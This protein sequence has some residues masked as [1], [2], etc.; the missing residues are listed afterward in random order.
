[1]DSAFRGP[2]D[3][4]GGWL[5]QAQQ[6]RS[7]QNSVSVQPSYRISQCALAVVVLPVVF[8][9]H[10]IDRLNVHFVWSMN[11]VGLCGSVSLSS[12]A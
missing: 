9:F 8:T 2:L 12:D 10:R 4:R 3:M 5:S 6:K 1:M 7:G 11:E